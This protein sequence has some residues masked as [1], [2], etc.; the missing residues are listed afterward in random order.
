M[1]VFFIVYICSIVAACTSNPMTAQNSG[2]LFHDEL[3]TPPSI[4]IHADDALAMSEPMQ[5]FV[6]KKFAHAM[7]HVQ[8]RDARQLLVESLYTKGDLRLQYYSDY[9]RTASEA[10]EAKSGNCL[11]LVLLSAAIAK[12]LKL[13]FHYQTVL[14]VTDWN[15]S[16]NLLMSIGHVNLVLESLPKEFELNTWTAQSSIIDFLTPDKATSLESKSIDESTVLAM[17]LNNRAVETLISGKVNDAYWWTRA[18]I[19]EDPTFTNAYL[20]LGVIY[21]ALHRPDLSE[22]VLESVATYDPNNTTLIS[23]QILVLKDLGREAEANRLA[24]RLAIL[25]QQRPWSYYFEAQN[26]FNAG[27]YMK[28]RQ[29]YEKEIA[30]DPSHHEFEFGLAETYV[31]LRDQKNAIAHLERAIELKPDKHYREFYQTKLEQLKSMGTM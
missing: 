13:P 23:N 6:R 29:L 7:G 24:E 25:D 12:E 18:A 14:G 22:V 11:S 26:E 17:Y 19:V 27:H 20:T 3:L 9:T 2:R 28:A 8:N 5:D 31:K 21:R 15:Q 1:R 16:D 10:F 4:V 30:R